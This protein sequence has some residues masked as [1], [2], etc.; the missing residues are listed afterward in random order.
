MGKIDMKAAV[1]YNT[2]QP[3]VI[4]DN[5][6]IPDLL[7]GQVLVKVA[8]SGVCHSQLMEARGKR[9]I[10]RHLP[11][12]LGHEG[13][14]TVLE[15]GQ[16]V[17]K[18]KSG[19]KIILGWIKGRGMDVS[20]TKYKKGNLFINAGGVTTFSDYTIVSENRCT[21]LPDGISFD[22]AVLFGC[23]IPTGAGIVMN[24]IKPE[25]GATVAIFGLGG[26]GLS[27]LMVTG[28]FEYGKII[29]VDIEENKLKLAHE[30]GATHTINAE[31]EN[32]LDVINSI[33]SGK[34]VDYS[35]ESS[36][37]AKTIETAFNSVRRFGGL[38]VFASHPKFGEKIELDP[39][40]LISGKQIEGSWGGSINPDADI[41]RL[42]ELYRE[43]KLPL[44][45]LLSHKYTLEQI[46][47]AL[48]DLENRKIVRA[49][50]E[51]DGSGNI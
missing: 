21:K 19:D 50:I 20:G 24:R 38:C 49:L 30:L 31:K 22:E 26:I 25:P 41:P 34:G 9:G 42:A 10:D 7:P 39:H 2:G 35:I 5:L 45:K 12:M 8:Y 6:K 4:E 17:T 37:I 40:E 44:R 48:N 32:P 28:L 14:G 3:L 33:T 23:A 27:A 51:M 15:T 1:L 43:R 36:G 46:N 18:L 47:Q 16:R 13:S 29:A 11:H